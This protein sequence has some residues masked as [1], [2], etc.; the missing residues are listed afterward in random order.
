MTQRS[1]GCA[2][3]QTSG[4]TLAA[5]ACLIVALLVGIGP[6]WS[7][8]LIGIGGEIWE[9]YAKDLRVDPIAP[10]CV[11]ADLDKQ[12]AACPNEEAAAPAGDV[13]DPFADEDP[14]AE[15]K[16][17]PTA[18]EDPFAEYRDDPELAGLFS[19]ASVGLSCD[20]PEWELEEDDVFDW[21]TVLD[22]EDAIRLAKQH[23]CES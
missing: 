9:G 10:V 17:E 11:L 18:D 5:L 22:I 20:S 14:F 19:S 23:Q 1:K 12:I 6:N 15:E 4:A 2:I 8:R 21:S 16:A 3:I 13:G 7:S